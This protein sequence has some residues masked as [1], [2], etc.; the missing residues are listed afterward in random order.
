[1]SRFE[2]ETHGYVDLNYPDCGK[3][4]FTESYPSKQAALKAF[5]LAKKDANNVHARVYQGET[6]FLEW[7]YGEK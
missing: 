5:H 4:H 2:L 6:T 1:M 7:Y 3:T